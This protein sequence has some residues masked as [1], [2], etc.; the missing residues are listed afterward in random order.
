MD[1]VFDEVGELPLMQVKI[2][3]FTRNRVRRGE[4]TSRKVDVRI[5]A[6]TAKDLKSEVEKGAFLEDLF[7]G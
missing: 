2:L 3:R 7:T 6:A 5:V 1:P 4:T